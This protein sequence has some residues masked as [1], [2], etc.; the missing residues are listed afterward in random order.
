[1]T[2][3]SH[4]TFVSA[5]AGSGKTWRLTEELEHLLVEDG[6][7]PARI[8]GTTFT[9][10]A[11]AELRDRVRE[12]LIASGRFALAEQSGGALIGTVHSVCERV[13]RRFAFEQGLSPR[14]DIASVEDSERLFDQALDDVLDPGRIRE[15]NAHG[16]RLELD[17]WQRDVKEIA[18]LARH[19]NL[20]VAA[21]VAMGRANAD[22]LLGFFPQAVDDDLSPAL[23]TAVELAVSRIDLDRDATKT[24]KNYLA[25]LRTAASR[26]GGADCPW[27]LWMSLSKEKPAKASQPVAEPVWTAASRYDAHP[28]FHEDVRRYTEGAFEIAAQALDRFA[29]LKRRAGL[30]DFGDMEQLMLRALDDKRVAGRL[31]EELDVLLVDEFQDTNPMQLALFVKLAGLADRVIFV[32]D[33]KQAI[34]GFRGCDQALVFDTLE[35]LAAGDATTLTLEHNW[36]SRA[37][38]VDYVNAVFATAFRASLDPS[39]VVLTPKRDAATEAPAVARW[40]LAGGGFDDRFA[41]LAAGIADLVASG[42]PVVD[43]R[44]GAVRPVRYGDIAVLARTNPRVEG[45]ARA[46][47]GQRVP[48]KMTMRGLLSVPEIGLARACL[49]CLNDDSDTLAVA[50]V[51]A[52]AGGAPP[53]TWLSDRLSW[54][55]EGRESRDWDGGQPVV[56]RLRALRQTAASLSPLE[57]VVRVLNDAGIRETVT[58]WGP[59]SVKAAQRQRNLDAL[60][61][62]TLLYEEH[63]AAQHEAASLTGFLFWLEEPSSPELDLQPVVTAGDAVHVLTYHRAKGLEWPVVVLT[64]FDY[65]EMNRLWEPRMAQVEPFDIHTPLGGRAVRWWPDLFRRRTRGVPARHAIEASDEGTACA[66]LSVEEQRRLA[67]VGMSRA[68]DLLVV[69]LPEGRLRRGAW[70]E[71][72]DAPFLLPEGDSLE[73][74]HGTTVPT[75]VRDFQAD[76]GLAAGEPFAP[77]WFEERARNDFPRTP[78]RPSDAEPVAAATVAEVVAFGERIPVAGGDMTRVGD[79][80]HAVIAMVLVNPEAAGAEDCAQAILEAHGAA[81]SVRADDAVAAA[82]RFL[83]FVEERFRPDAIRVEYPIAH[84]LDDGRHAAGRIDVVLETAEGPVIL[85]HKSSPLAES[86]WPAEALKHSGQ[87]AAYR[88]AFEAAGRSAATWIHFAVSGGAVRVE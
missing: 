80:L 59:D 46:L 36:R 51:V 17:R 79:G 77:R 76:S 75:V 87:L 22:A 2:D 83:A 85:D 48:M 43:P 30:M 29:D 15:M 73:L 40:T 74:P 14:L 60:L 4:V 26:L 55:A 9:V 33:V 62:L 5:G 39:R 71:A 88:S 6:V 57:T 52:L 20:G 16:A 24:T 27:S 11:A 84:L 18:D 56:G 67:Y 23:E 81:D 10:K 44:S 64:D 37:P 61:D 65:E 86:E 25:R 50:E 19:N 13:L 47:R 45:I 3:F 41:A 49:R 72:F 38:L 1:M 54:L 21:L 82:R 69:A 66:R 34:F 63:S 68:R 12:R 70:L 42:Y 8:I 58:A 28:R 35:E 7:D 32:G 78:A 53:E 31:R